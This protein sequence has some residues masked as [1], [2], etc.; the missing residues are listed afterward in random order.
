MAIGAFGAAEQG[1]SLG[2]GPQTAFKKRMTVER[3]ALDGQGIK[4]PYLS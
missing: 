4:R 2:S 1:S 3:L